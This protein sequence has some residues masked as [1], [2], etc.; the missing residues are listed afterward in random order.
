MY[1]VEESS[2]NTFQLNYIKIKYI[3]LLLSLTKVNRTEGP[4]IRI[5]F[6]SNYCIILTCGITAA[7]LNVTVVLIG[8][9]F[10]PITA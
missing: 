2:L 7:T 9:Q 4:L 8:H 10:Q 3:S 5:R 1:L 6:V